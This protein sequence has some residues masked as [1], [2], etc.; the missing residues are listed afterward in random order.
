MPENVRPLSRRGPLTR[1]ADAGEAYS[2][3]TWRPAI[4]GSSR[5]GSSA[6][7][8]CGSSRGRK[9]RNVEP[10]PGPLSTVTAP[11]ELADDAVHD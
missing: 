3:P 8:R 9:T 11:D 10:W 1:R 2:V 7:L 6:T 5:S 4:G